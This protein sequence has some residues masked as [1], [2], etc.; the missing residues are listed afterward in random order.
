MIHSWI[1]TEN[2]YNNKIELYEKGWCNMNKYSMLFSRAGEGIKNAIVAIFAGSIL[3]TLIVYLYGLREAIQMY[4]EDGSTF[5]LLGLFCVFFAIP[6]IVPYF[7]AGV[8]AELF[9]L[10]WWSV[11]ILAILTLF[12]HSYISI[13]YGLISSPDI[14]AE[15]NYILLFIRYIP[16]FTV[17]LFV[18]LYGRAKASQEFN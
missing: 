17:F 9:K 5:I 4:G 2:L 15:Q 7:V 14:W 11:I 10:P 13:R 6:A 16:I 3:S 12:Y 1:L 8:I 18:S